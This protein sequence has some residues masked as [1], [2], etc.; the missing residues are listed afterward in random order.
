[1]AIDRPPREPSARIIQFDPARARRPLGALK[2]S[3]A[4]QPK[5]PF[6]LDQLGPV[7][8]LST[9]QGARSCLLALTEEGLW[10][11]GLQTGA[12]QSVYDCY[13]NEEGFIYALESLAG[14]SRLLSHVVKNTGRILRVPNAGEA[15]NILIGHSQS[16]RANGLGGLVGVNDRAEFRFY[17]MLDENGER[18]DPCLAGIALL[19]DTNYA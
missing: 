12:M 13:I 17:Y 10:S 18:V 16:L 7:V 11:L 1:M 15:A 6:Q 3:R 2:P 19:D 4:R 9:P 5:Q 8:N 14:F